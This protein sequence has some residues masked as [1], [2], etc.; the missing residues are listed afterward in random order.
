MIGYVV[1]PRCRPD[2][3][4]HNND[5]AGS[6]GVLHNC[7]YFVQVIFY[8]PVDIEVHADN[9]N[10]DFVTHYFRDDCMFIRVLPN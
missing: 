10:F 8:L 2:V 6:F 5:C 4:I 3:A 9:N 1:V 7:F